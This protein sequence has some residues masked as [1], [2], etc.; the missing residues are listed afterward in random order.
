MV[1]IY[2]ICDNQKV[3]LFPDAEPAVICILERYPFRG[4]NAVLAT[5]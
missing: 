2:I 5:K 1:Y 4:T 3:R